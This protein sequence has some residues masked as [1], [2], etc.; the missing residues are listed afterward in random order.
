[1]QSWWNWENDLLKLLDPSAYLWAL[2]LIRITHKLSLKLAVSIS[3]DQHNQLIMDKLKFKHYWN[4]SG[5]CGRT[6]SDVIINQFSAYSVLMRK[7]KID[8]PNYRNARTSDLFVFGPI[9]VN[10]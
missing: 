9:T 5:Y 4:H 1:M 10:Y 3:Y 6:E 7:R 8:C 2:A